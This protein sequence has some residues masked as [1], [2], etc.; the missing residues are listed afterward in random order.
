MMYQNFLNNKYMPSSIIL[1][2][3]LGI[4]IILGLF[5]IVHPIIIIFIFI[6]IFCIY[7]LYWINIVKRRR[8]EFRA[9]ENNFIKNLLLKY[10]YYSEKKIKYLI[11]LCNEEIHKKEEKKQ[12]LISVVMF[13]IPLIISIIALL[14]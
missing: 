5:N 8:G 9:K 7:F 12:F 6:L 13:I 14:K 10:N 2:I 3:I 4:L 11:E 1:I